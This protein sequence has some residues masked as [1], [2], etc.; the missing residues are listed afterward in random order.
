MNE[1]DFLEKVSIFSYMKKRDLRR[2]AKMARHHTYRKGD[3]I[4]NE[5]DRDGRLFIILCGKVEVIKNL[6]TKNKR[7]LRTLGPENY[8]G[9]MALI[10]DFVRSASVVA[11]EETDVLSLDQ[12]NL[13]QEFEKYPV[14]AIELLQVM[15]RRLRAVEKNL[16][17]SLGTLLPICANCKK[18]RDENE[19][20]TPIEEYISD[21]SETEFSHSICPDCAK[22]L[23]PDFGQKG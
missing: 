23:Y 5:G 22:K 8:F 11:I 4:I 14:L 17:N 1:S 12:W 10:D 16:I 15:N 21:H 9:E 18:I 3:V 2:I 13:R 19:A 20:W 6:G 7:C